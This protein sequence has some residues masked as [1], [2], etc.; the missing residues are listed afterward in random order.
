MRTE[1]EIEDY[2]SQDEIKEIVA[3]ELRCIIGRRLSNENEI[4][5]ILINTAYKTSREEIEKL[6]PGYKDTLDAEVKRCMNSEE[7][8]R[9][10]VFYKY[11]SDNIGL[12]TKY[13]NESITKHKDIIEEKV[14]KEIRDHD[15]K[16]DV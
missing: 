16:R 5:R 4:E 13:L 6:I 12:E 8:I 1:I 2:L 11:G 9:Y 7:T 15:Y 10:N 3:D 14:V